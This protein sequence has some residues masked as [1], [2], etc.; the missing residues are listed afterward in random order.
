MTFLHGTLMA[1]GSLFMAIPIVLHLIMRRQ[2][3]HAF[4]PALRFVTAT[5][6]A[7]QRILRLKQWLLLALRCLAVAVLA[8]ALARP[9]LPP[10]WGGSR[11]LPTD[12]EA[13]VAALFLFDTSPR[14]RY[15]DSNQ[16]R[17]QV[18]QAAALRLVQQLPSGSQ[19]A[20]MTSE[21]R[22]AVFSS[23]IQ[24]A[25]AAI[26]ALEATS[27][28]A[29]LPDVLP[30]AR[31]L[32]EGQELKRREL[33]LFS[34]LTQRA[35][36][37]PQD[38]P[39][40]PSENH[41]T[42]RDSIRDDSAEVYVIDVGI[43][44]PRN[45]R[46]GDLQVPT[47]SLS[48]ASAVPI[49]V[50]VDS[51]GLD[52]PLDVA[53]EFHLESPSA[54]RPVV[55]DGTP[56]WPKS[57]LR[58]RARRRLAAGTTRPVRAV[59]KGLEEGVHHGRVR[60]VSSDGLAIDDERYFSVR[61]Q[62]PSRILVAAGPGAISRFVAEALAPIPLRETGRVRYEVESI[63]VQ[64]LP[65]YDLAAFAT[66]ILLD[67]PPLE[68]PTWGRLREY[69]QRG[70]ALILALGRNVG[71]IPAFDTVAARE[72]L[73]GRLARQWRSGGTPLMLAPRPEEHPMLAAFSARATSVPWRNFPVYRHWILRELKPTTSE[74]ALWSN[75]QPALLETRIEKGTVITLTSP[76]S[77]GLN[78]RKRAPW[79][80]IPTGPEPWPFVVLVNEM[81]EYLV[82]NSGS[83]LVF[84]TGESVT[85]RQ[86]TSVVTARVEV[87]TPRG[88]WR[89][90]VQEND[91]LALGLLDEPGI[92]RV[93]PNE[94][95]APVS[96]LSVNLSAAV[97]QLSRAAPSDLN[98][99]LG[100]DRYQLVSNPNQ[101]DREVS[102]AR[103][104]R[105]MLP[106]GLLILALL[107]AGEH[108]LANRI[109][110]A[111]PPSTL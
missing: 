33:Y 89:N 92:Y 17:L 5:L 53:I 86:P 97:T 103:V 21:D 63:S 52:S 39:V 69:V 26:R 7:N 64:D 88:T 60:V 94:S 36:N 16:T 13:P 29:P 1:A 77:D 31:A 9:V 6:V 72:L 18:A 76:L 61:I 109:Y 100:A 35:W 67:P 40:P 10:R 54:E 59:L 84:E 99:C 37:A 105:E 58:H 11:W 2:P 83:D 85:L 48:P 98:R 57:E 43:A 38:A 75:G 50:E 62:P 45:I 82:G 25:E 71:S 102:D 90:V 111:A 30:V 44:S 87:F 96:G 73:P 42:D 70:G 81:V 78:Q 49:E 107:M 46:L 47:R 74:I 15:L 55:I 95:G 3:R 19:C 51:E 106:F 8:F 12:Q 66:T 20:V 27:L 65:D 32:L 4:F 93:Y 22:G 24:A 110:Q 101:I 41:N 34:D 28:D 91:E 108:I 23:E 104:G 80:E 56:Q 14:M 79:N 68:D